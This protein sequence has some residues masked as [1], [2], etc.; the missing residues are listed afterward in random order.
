MD[1]YKELELNDWDRTYV[2]FLILAIFVP[3]YIVKLFSL[4]FL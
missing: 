2:K 4:Y 3:K 1:S